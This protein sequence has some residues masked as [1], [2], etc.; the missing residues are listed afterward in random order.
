MKDM[1]LSSFFLTFGV[2]VI[3]ANST[4]AVLATGGINNQQIFA[5]GVGMIASVIGI[6]KQ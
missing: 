1:L 2:T 3:L 4:L 6:A 5:I